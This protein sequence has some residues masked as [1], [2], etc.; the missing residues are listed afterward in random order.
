MILVDLWQDTAAEKGKPW[1]QVVAR[2]E[3]ACYEKPP[4][5]DVWLYLSRVD[6]SDLQGYLSRHPS[7]VGRVGEVRC[8]LRQVDHPIILVTSRDVAGR[9][10]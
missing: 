6:F 10:E 2:L 7:L 4:E 1:L 8:Q 3:E 9:R 5:S